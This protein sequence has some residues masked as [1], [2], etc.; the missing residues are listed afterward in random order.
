MI[1]YHARWA[2]T[3]HTYRL[4]TFR[5][6]ARAPHADMAG[7]IKLE[8]R[9]RAKAD[10]DYGGDVRKVCDSVRGAFVFHSIAAFTAALGLLSRGR[11]I[12]P[13]FVVLRVKDRVRTPLKNGYRDVL[14]NV[15][16]PNTNLVVELQLHFH[17]VHELKVSTTRS[18]SNYPHTHPRTRARMHT[19]AHACTR[20][21]TYGTRTRV[22][23]PNPLSCPTADESPLIRAEAGRWVG[24][25]KLQV[26]A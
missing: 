21:R 14:V 15:I 3:E 2:S 12:F 10:L 4:D 24:P 20:S 5:F 11:G 13:Q 19:H 22:Y 9:L 1:S 23:P 7:P 25:R 18:S 8:T 17:A 16:V 6:H 26:R